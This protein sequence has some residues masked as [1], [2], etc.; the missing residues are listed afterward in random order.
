MIDWPALVLAGVTLGALL[1][2]VYD[3]GLGTEPDNDLDA[4][5][6]AECEHEETTYSF[7]T[8][9][10]RCLLCGEITEQEVWD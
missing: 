7:T 9:V 10:T 5:R 1:W 2:V 4:G 3:L 8:G 6:I